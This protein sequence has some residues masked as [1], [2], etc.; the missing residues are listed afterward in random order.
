MVHAIYPGSFDPLHNGHLDVIE[1]ISKIYDQV[2]VAVL[3]N[4]LK[5]TKT[6]NID[7]RLTIIQTSV[8]G[9]ENVKAEKFEG[10]LVNYVRS[11]NAQ[12]VVKGLRSVFD[13]DYELQMAHLNRHVSGDIDTSFMMTSAH[14]SYV[15]STRVKELAT[16]GADISELV[17]PATL[18]ALKEKFSG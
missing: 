15:S 13:F 18:K 4:P 1:R 14:W 16:Y 8:E 12:I 7:E 9:L 11:Q 17:P 3:D 5:N 6:F 10:L 2:T